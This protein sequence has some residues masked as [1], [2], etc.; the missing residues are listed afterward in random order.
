ML[1]GTTSTFTLYS[2]VISLAALSRP[3][4]PRASSARLT[5]SA[6]SPFAAALPIPMLPPTI[7][8]VRPCKPSSIRLSSFQQRSSFSL[9][10]RFA[11]GPTQKNLQFRR[12]AREWIRSEL[13]DFI[14]HDAGLLIWVL[15]QRSLKFLQALRATVLPLH[16]RYSNTD[17][18]CNNGT[19]ESSY[20]LSRGNEF[21]N[22]IRAAFAA[23][24]LASLCYTMHILHY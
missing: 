11:H 18:I 3:S 12:A 10:A 24:P 16:R 20:F 8:A 6:A 13:K 9:V 17:P 15:R 14:L 5:P 2:A 1:V 19:T 23:V 4:C 7:T 21:R 22:R